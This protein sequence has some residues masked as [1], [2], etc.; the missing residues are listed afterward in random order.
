MTPGRSVIEAVLFDATGTLIEL[1][2]PVGETYAEAAR[3]QGVELPAWRVQDAFERVQA[4]AEPRVHPELRDLAAIAAAERDEW[5]DVV[6]Q[7]FQ[8]VDSTLRFPRPDELAER[9]FAHYADAA[10]WRLRPGV[11]AALRALADDGLRAGVVS[12]FD[13]RLSGILQGLGIIDDLSCIVLPA[14]CGA[15][16]PDPRIFEAALAALG[17]PAERVAFVGDD[18]DKDLAG[19][20]A[21]GLL[22]IDIRGWTSL[23]ELPRRLHDAANL[24]R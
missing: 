9:L 17:L 3:D 24:A 6:R 21:A 18:P 16:K 8:A 19:A 11:R 23:E 1:V 14:H 13:L 12:N 15:R 7:T 5:K 10:A 2:R 4:R 22:A 20:R